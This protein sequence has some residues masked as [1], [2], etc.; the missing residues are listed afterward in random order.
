MIT[1]LKN[2]ISRLE[3]KIPKTENAISEA[4]LKV[5]KMRE[6][7]SEDI[8]IIFI[9]SVYFFLIKLVYFQS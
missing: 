9:L 7:L 2:S 4:R 3:E 8:G 1:H 6:E 5:Q